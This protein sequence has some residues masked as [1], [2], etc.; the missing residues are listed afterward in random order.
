M[1][2]AAI[3][4]QEHCKGDT[5]LFCFISRHA[6]VPTDLTG[7]IVRMMIRETYDADAPIVTLDSSYTPV[8]PLTDAGGPYGT[9]TIADPLSG[10]V[11]FKITDEVTAQFEPTKGVY[12]IEFENA[13][14][15][16][17]KL[18]RGKFKFLPEAT[19]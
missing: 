6:G 1:S 15:D 4:N 12:D 3:Y 8:D 11:V 17:T 7:Y 9:V 19:R 18:L 2:C 16:V 10:E 14:G 5:Y 13:S